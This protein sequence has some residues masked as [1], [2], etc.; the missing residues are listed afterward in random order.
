MLVEPDC[1]CIVQAAIQ[2]T[3]N[4]ERIDL[5]NEKDDLPLAYGLTQTDVTA[6][7]QFKVN[8]YVQD[9]QCVIVANQ[10]MLEVFRTSLVQT[11]T[12]QKIEFSRVLLVKMD[13]LPLHLIGRLESFQFDL[14]DKNVFYAIGSTNQAFED[15]A[16]GVQAAEE[17]KAQTTRVKPQFRI[18]KFFIDCEET[19]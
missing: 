16:E 2:P 6:V 10:S 14:F 5:L 11:Q 15:E 17:M 12:E 8:Q 18:E 13:D 9:Q 3:L 1:I 19:F 7:D 4:G